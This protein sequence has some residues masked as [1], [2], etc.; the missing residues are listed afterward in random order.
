M[1]YTKKDLFIPYQFLGFADVNELKDSIDYLE[2]D[3][4]GD[5]AASSDSLVTLTQAANKKIYFSDATPN[6]IY[7][8]TEPI[9]G[10]RLKVSGDIENV[11]TGEIVGQ[12]EWITIAAPLVVAAN[13]GNYFGT[14]ANPWSYG[15]G[16]PGSITAFTASVVSTTASPTCDLK[17]EVE[18]NGS[19]ILQS[20][21]IQIRTQ[22]TNYNF[23]ATYTRGDYTFAAGDYLTLLGMDLISG[24][25]NVKAA[26]L[27]EI[28]FDT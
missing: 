24:S 28:V 2:S 8:K 11:G 14:G 10:E 26:V 6:H 12:R 3:V 16:R 1:A 18:K 23:S 15:M 4:F 9:I 20:T 25:A 22:Y 19:V 7:F 5:P 13:D 27:L 21:T 17:V